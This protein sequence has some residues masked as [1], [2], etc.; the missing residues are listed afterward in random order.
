M[1]SLSELMRAY[2]KAYETKDRAAMESTISSD[3]TFTSPYDDQISGSI[4]RF[5]D[6]S[7]RRREALIKPRPSM[8]TCLRSGRWRGAW[9]ELA[10]PLFSLRDLRRR[11]FLL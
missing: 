6:R 1:P 10:R 2:F 7:C 5:Q 3:F 8:R 11:D 4:F 9:L